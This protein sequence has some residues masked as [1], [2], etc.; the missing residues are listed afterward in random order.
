[1]DLIAHKKRLNAELLDQILLVYAITAAVSLAG[2]L[3]RAIDIGFLPIM[4]LHASLF[5]I[6]CSLVLFRHSIPYPYKLAFVIIATY[7]IGVAGLFTF[8]MLGGNQGFLITVVILLSIIATSF[9][10]L[11]IAINASLILAAGILITQGYW[12]VSIDPAQYMA[13]M[14][15][16]SNLAT[17]Y[18]LSALI[19]ILVIK[20]RIDLNVMLTEKTTTLLAENRRLSSSLLQSQDK[21]RTRMAYELHDEIGQSLNAIH[22]L[23]AIISKQSNEK[24]AIIHANNIIHAVKQTN[25]EI[26]N[27]L[28]ELQP[29]HL[30]IMSLEDAVAAH[31][32]KWQCN[33][34]TCASFKCTGDS[35]RIPMTTA[36]HLYRIIQESLTNVAKHASACLAEVYLTIEANTTIRLEIH[37][38]GTGYLPGSNNEGLGLLSTQQRVSILNGHCDIRSAPTKG[39]HITITIPDGTGPGLATKQQ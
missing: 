3:Y 7:A 16:W 21:L 37:D 18:L 30:E 29:H 38:D 5:A 28:H 34:S 27:I 22:C 4:T 26:R 10:F 35:T 15:S 2:S 32:K 20:K 8:G 24:K 13:S 31:I 11:A 9:G 17:G 6:L 33:T 19:A 14:S 36:A 39:T 12:H 25:G 23:A 1:L